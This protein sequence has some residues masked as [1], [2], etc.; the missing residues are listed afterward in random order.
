[1]ATATSFNSHSTRNSVKPSESHSGLTTYSTSSARRNCLIALQPREIV[2]NT[3]RLR[4]WQTFRALGAVLANF[5]VTHRPHDLRLLG[6]LSENTLLTLALL[7]QGVLESAS[8][9]RLLLRSL[10]RYRP[11]EGGELLLHYRKNNV[12]SLCFWQKHMSA[13]TF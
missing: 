9:L 6:A 1:M 13:V 10:Q 7:P 12:R 8:K 2:Q 4:E 11:S 3:H 5:R